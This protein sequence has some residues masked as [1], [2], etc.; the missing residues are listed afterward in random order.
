MK[1]TLKQ[2]G[3]IFFFV[4]QIVAV[5]YAVTGSLWMLNQASDLITFGGFLALVLIAYAIRY[6]ARPS[7]RSLLKA[8]TKQIT[9]P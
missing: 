8:F 1:N 5:Y 3:A 6:R 2:I 4:L 9:K 7:F